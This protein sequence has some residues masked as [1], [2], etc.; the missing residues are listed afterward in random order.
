MY[1]C[2]VYICDVGRLKNSS[3]LC[4]LNGFCY[5]KGLEKGWKWIVRLNFCFEEKFI[6]FV[7]FVVSEVS[8]ISLFVVIWECDKMLGMIKSFKVED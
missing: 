7:V 1:V 3:F 2:V 6:F 8:F 4:W 5:V